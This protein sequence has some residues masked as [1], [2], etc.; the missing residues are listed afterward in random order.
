MARYFKSAESDN[1]RDIYEKIKVLLSGHLSPTAP[2]TDFAS[3][4]VDIDSDDVD[5]DVVV[6]ISVLSSSSV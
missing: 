2:S 4:I 6:P 1:Y 3:L 5:Q